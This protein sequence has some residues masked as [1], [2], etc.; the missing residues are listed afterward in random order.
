M[1]YVCNSYSTYRATN[2]G[3]EGQ[4][5]CIAVNS[6][7]VVVVVLVVASPASLS[8][9]SNEKPVF[10]KP[11]RRTTP[12]GFMKHFTMI[13][14]N[15]THAMILLLYYYY[16]Y[17]K[18]TTCDFYYVATIYYYRILLSPLLLLLLQLE[19]LLLR[20]LPHPLFLLLLLLQPTITNCGH[21]Y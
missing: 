17:F 7:Q 2:S 9:T 21:R 3:K 4:R 5:Q 15:C 13:V 18:Q 20:L 14:G 12:S 1:G 11:N 19:L 16:Y 10:T 8:P 6:G